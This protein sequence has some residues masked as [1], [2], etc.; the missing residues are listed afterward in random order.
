MRVAP[1]FATQTATLQ[2]F[3]QFQGP[4]LVLREDRLE[5]GLALLGVACP[6]LS[7]V[8]DPSA[9]LLAGIYDAELE[10]AAQ[11]AYSRDYLGYGFGPWR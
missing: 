2:G 11:E 7:N 10:D 9:D 4:D 3:A 6:A 1:Q 5:T 8:Q